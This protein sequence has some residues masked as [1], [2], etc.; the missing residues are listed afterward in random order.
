MRKPD[1]FDPRLKAYLRRGASTPPRAGMEARILGRAPERKAAWALQ[2]AAAAAV[3]VLAIGLGIIV[4]HARESSVGRPMPTESAAPSLKPTPY[5][6]PTTSGTPYPLVGSASVHMVN[7]STGWASA[8]GADRIIRTADGGA[9]WE[10]VTPHGAQAGTWT[11]FFL[12]ANNAWLA[13]S[14]QPG[15]GSP[16][17]SVKLYRTSDGGRSWPYVGAALADFGFPAAMDFVDRNN[18]WVFMRQDGTLGTPG[19]DRVAFYGTRDGGATWSKLSETDASG[20]P[21]QLPLHCSKVAPVFLNSST[22]WMPGA[23]NVEAVGPFLYV[24]RDGGRTWRDVGIA[25][26]AGLAGN[27]ICEIHSLRFSDSRNGVFVLTS[28]ASSGAQQ[29][30]LYSTTD[31]GNSWRPGASLPALT[32]EAFF[33]DNSHGWT[34]NGKANNSVFYTSDGGQHWSTLGTIPSYGGV[35]DLQFVNATIGWARGAETAGATLIKTS[36]GGRTWTT[37]LA[38]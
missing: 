7:A 22:G 27:C 24:T 34:I 3:L 37:Q 4:Q 16:D 6:T 8:S 28:S 20:A 33:I 36:D 13:S 29:S 12:D 10:D 17:F 32:Y 18:G 1:E 38:P 11:T 9:H 14:L 19:S 2:L 31:A 25:L 15:S 21:G 30:F 23:C 26:P 5:P 35:V